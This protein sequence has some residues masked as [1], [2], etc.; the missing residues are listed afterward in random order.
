[1][2]TNTVVAPALDCSKLIPD[3]YRT[4]IP[5][6]AVPKPD[7]VTGRH[8]TLADVMQFA[9]G[10][11]AAL[12]RANGRTSDVISLVD[13]CSASNASMAKQLQP[14]PWWHVW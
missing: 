13:L 3:G 7:P 1:M 4:P 2:T 5:G 11:S 6:A 8:V 9:D 10:Q 12:D 14:K